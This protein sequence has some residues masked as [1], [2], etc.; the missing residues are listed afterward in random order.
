MCYVSV[1]CSEIFPPDCSTGDPPTLR[2]TQTREEPSDAKRV[3]GL[4][5]FFLTLPARCHSNP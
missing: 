1:D 4:A 3:N 2:H 5:P